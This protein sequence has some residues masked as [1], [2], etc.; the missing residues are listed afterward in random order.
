MLNKI[1]FAGGCFWGVQK[2]FNS[3]SGVKS[4]QVG[5]ANGKGEN[6]DYKTVCAGKGGYKETVEVCYDEKTIP[7]SLLCQAFFQVIDPAQ[8]NAQ[9]HD[10]GEQYQ[11]GIFYVDSQAELEKIYNA[12][13]EKHEKF[14]VL[15]QPL[16]NF[17]PAETYHQ[18]YLEKNPQGY[19]HIMP[20]KLKEVAEK[21]NSRINDGK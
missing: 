6:P 17:Y 8:Q 13:K 4:T 19:C 10:V 12:E 18:N 5:Y 3:L 2:L 21:I 1:Y 15:F 7:L 11:T 20:D 16:D 14:F 9:G